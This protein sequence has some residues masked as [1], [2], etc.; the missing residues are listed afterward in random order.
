MAE[1]LPTPIPTPAPAA[2]AAPAPVAPAST[3]PVAPPV[4]PAP[5]TP[6][7]QESPEATFTSS[8]DAGLD[9]AFSFFNK[10]GLK[11]DDYAVQRAVEGDFG[12]IEAWIAGLPPE[13]TKGWEQYLQLGKDSLA[14]IS[15]ANA[16]SEEARIKTILDEVG[17]EENWNAIANFVAENSEPEEKEAFKSLL[18]EGGIKSRIAAG[19]LKTLYA[20]SANVTIEG[21]NAVNPVTPAAHVQSGPLTLASY[22]QEVQKLVAEVGGNRVQDDPRYAALRQKYANVTA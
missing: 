8:G 18:A 22:R 6:A 3:N 12:A 7:V 1:E 17:G 15:E 14:R 19:Y 13:K 20:S 4:Q 10:L 21:A 9:M 2:P 16:K 11:E 5:A